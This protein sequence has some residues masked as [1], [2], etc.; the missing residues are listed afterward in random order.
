MAGDAGIVAVGACVG[1]DA[2]SKFERGPDFG[3]AKRIETD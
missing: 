1:E 2:G 3:T